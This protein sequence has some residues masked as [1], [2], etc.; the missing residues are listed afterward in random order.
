MKELEP[1]EVDNDFKNQYLS[2][3]LK[4]HG[5]PNWLTFITLDKQILMNERP[6]IWAFWWSGNF[7]K[8]IIELLKQNDELYR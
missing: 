5:F 6:N 8:K 7:G 3:K 2:F 4:K 1:V